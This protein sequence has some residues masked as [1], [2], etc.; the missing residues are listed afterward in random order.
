M[1]TRLRL[2]SAAVNDAVRQAE[3]KGL[4]VSEGSPPHSLCL[5]AAGGFGS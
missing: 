2:D 4:L 1:G 5:K 3:T